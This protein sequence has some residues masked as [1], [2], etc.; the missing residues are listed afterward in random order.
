MKSDIIDISLCCQ[1]NL[2]LPTIQANITAFYITP[3]ML[4][5]TYLKDIRKNRCPL[6]STAI[7]N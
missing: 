6:V 3:P 5:E 7:E 2:L 1:L 4:I